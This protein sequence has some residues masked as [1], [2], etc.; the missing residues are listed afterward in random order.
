MERR[1]RYFRGLK[2]KLECGHEHVEVTS[3]YRLNKDRAACLVG[4]FQGTG[5]W[6]SE[7]GALCQP[8]YLGT[9]RGDPNPV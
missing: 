5:I 3:F 1:K 7:C 9:V 4:H 8:T 6:C 2:F